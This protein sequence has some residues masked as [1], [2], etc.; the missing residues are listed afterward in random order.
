MWL[1]K[2]LGPAAAILGCRPISVDMTELIPREVF[3]KNPEKAGPQISP[4]GKQLAYLAPSKEGV[5]NIWIRTLG[6]KDDRQATADSGNGIGIYAWAA[7]S[8]RLLYFQ[9]RQG[10]EVQHLYSV[11]P[12]T[13]T[14]RDLTPFVGV[15]AQNLLT[16]PEFPNQVLVGMNLR[17]RRVFDMYRVDLDSGA[18][19]LDTENP[20]DVLSWVVD[21]QF[22]IR[23]CSAIL[24]DAS[25]E[26]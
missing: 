5:L 13:K 8:K 18:V 19:Q 11:D 23:A 7:D 14:I 22:R 10:D 3:F 15:R 9:D 4:D 20:G 1:L 2:L 12:A 16:H 25:T 21:S 26:I 17:N 6:R 24:K